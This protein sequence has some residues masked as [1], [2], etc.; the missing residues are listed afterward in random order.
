MNGIA[1]GDLLR[2]PQ[3]PA[4]AK[5]RRM[6]NFGA[7]PPGLS[8]HIGR[9]TQEPGRGMGRG[10]RCHGQHAQLGPESNSALSPNDR[11]FDTVAVVGRYA[12][13]KSSHRRGSRCTLPDGPLARAGL[14][15]SALPRADASEEATTLRARA[16][17]GAD[18]SAI[19]GRIPPMRTVWPNRCH[20]AG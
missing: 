5:R 9:D 16:P 6:T 3:Q 10:L 13:R 11:N 12:D 7:P 19:F 8:E 14:L 17:L 20:G 4:C 15:P 18:C 1:G 2:L